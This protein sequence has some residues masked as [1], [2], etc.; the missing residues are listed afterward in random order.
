MRYVHGGD[1]K[2]ALQAPDLDA[3]VRPERSVEIGER[4]VEEEDRGLSNHRPAHGHTLALASG[5]LLRLAIQQR[6]DAEHLGGPRNPLSDLLS[7]CLP[8]TKAQREVLAHRHVRV[9]R[10]V[11][12]HHRH[13][14]GTR[15]QGGHVLISDTDRPGRH[16]LETGQHA[17]NGRLA[18]ARA[19]HEHQELTVGDLQVEVLDHSGVAEPLGDM[20]E[21]YGGH[22]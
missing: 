19:P 17:Q 13:I 3:H 18:A 14:T 6:V 21:R 8:E 2:P 10:I 1:P 11:L 12:K 22:C 5:Q 9:E 4:L 20:L 7:G 16:R 15:G